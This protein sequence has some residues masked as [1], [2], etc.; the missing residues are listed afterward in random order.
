MSEILAEELS[1]P[2]RTFLLQKTSRNLVNA[3]TAHSFAHSLSRR[4]RSSSS[5]NNNNNMETLVGRRESD[6]QR[7]E[8]YALA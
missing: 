4:R 3:T 6:D 8:K 2:D 5:N 1:K 7:E